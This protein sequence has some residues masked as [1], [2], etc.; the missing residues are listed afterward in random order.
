MK[1]YHYNRENGEFIVEGIADKSPLEPGVFLIPAHATKIKP[2]RLS[3]GKTAIFENDSWVIKDDNRGTKYWLPND[4]YGAEPRVVTEIGPVRKDAIF[5]PPPQPPKT[6]EEL[7]N[8]ER[9]KNNQNIIKNHLKMDDK[10]FGDFIDLIT[11]GF[12]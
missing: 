8:I 4:E 10:M 12:E 6:Q 9:K 5:E 3:K 2:P 7:D 1:I 11:T